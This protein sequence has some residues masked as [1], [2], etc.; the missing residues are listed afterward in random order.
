MSKLPSPVEFRKKS[1]ERPVVKLHY[2]S[3]VMDYIALMKPRVMALVVFTSF[4]GLWLAPNT[5]HPFIAF[6][7][8]LCITLGA[9]SSAAINMWYDRDIDA[10][11]KR[12]QNRPI[13]IKAIK[14]EDALAFGVVL[15]FSSVFLMGLCVNLLSSFLLLTTILYYI[16]IYTIWLKRTTIQ[17]IVIGG[18]AGALPPVIGWAVV[19]NNISIESCSLFLII[20]AW[21]PPHSWALALF[22]SEDYKNCNIPMMPV[23][24]GATY[25]KKQIVIYS[26][27]M[28]ITSFL[29]YFLGLSHI[30]Y[31]VIATI[32]G[33]I[34]LY[35]AFSLFKD[36]NN[37][38]AKKLFAYS[39]FYL[40]IIFLTLDLSRIY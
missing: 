38:Q 11:M 5:I 39:I 6:I 20:L 25:T 23:I 16:F 36:Q 37:R 33:I 28:F 27:M 21:T 31:L 13:V 24:K 34:F 17:N 10:I 3:S 18:A 2:D 32:L 4:S 22:R 30:I 14:P 29:P 8:M 12:T 15:A 9:G 7:A 26:I 19:A 35:Y 40:F 1:I